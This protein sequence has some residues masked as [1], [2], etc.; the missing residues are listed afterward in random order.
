[1]LN[2]VK[3]MF[4]INWAWSKSTPIC[5]DDDTINN[6]FIDLDPEY[7]ET[8]KDTVKVIID[9]MVQEIIDKSEKEFVKK[10]I[11][12]LAKEQIYKPTNE[13]TNESTNELTNEPTNESTNE[14]TNEPTNEPR[15][16]LVKNISNNYKWFWPVLIIGNVLVGGYFIIK[17]LQSKN[18]INS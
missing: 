14:S 2:Y 17:T 7:D 6:D 10:S 9:E 12:F 15:H 3:K 1:M 4:G 16:K 5:M 8:C 18:K 13:S 11:N